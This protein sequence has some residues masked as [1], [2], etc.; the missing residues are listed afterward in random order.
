MLRLF[1]LF[2]FFFIQKKESEKGEGRNN[3]CY[4]VIFVYGYVEVFHER[5]L[6]SHLSSVFY[7]VFTVG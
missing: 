7:K 2:N 5:K 3:L 4:R 1:S 6:S